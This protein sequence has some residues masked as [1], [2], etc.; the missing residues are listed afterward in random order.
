MNSVKRTLQSIQ[1]YGT[2]WT[3]HMCECVRWRKL[4]R[5]GERKNWNWGSQSSIVLTLHAPLKSI[6]IEL[7]SQTLRFSRRCF[8]ALLKWIHRALEIPFTITTDE[9]RECVWIQFNRRTFFSLFYFFAIA[10]LDMPFLFRHHSKIVWLNWFSL[11]GS[12]NLRPILN[13]NNNKT[14]QQLMSFQNVRGIWDIKTN[15]EREQRPHTQ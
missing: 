14:K 1:L 12:Q 7:C 5:V 4:E 10:T 6:G 3:C 11:F 2:H 13:I 9:M 8:H 15:T